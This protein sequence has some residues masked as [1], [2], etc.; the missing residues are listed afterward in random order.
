[1]YARIKSG[2]SLAEAERALGAA[3]SAWPVTPKAPRVT[4]VRLDP[5]FDDAVASTSDAMPVIV[6]SVLVLVALVCVN[7]A[8]LI[9]ADGTER[10]REFAVRA[11][12]GAGRGRLVRQLLTEASV[13][14]VIACGVG[15]L[16][17]WWSLVGLL[18]TTFAF[19]GVN[20]FLSGLHSYGNL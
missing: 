15:V 19:L 2:V 11:S 7:V 6:L 1:M 9:F 5:L 14:G 12:M 4:G 16:L 8:G 18:I 3:A 20:I 13:L 17:A 10:R